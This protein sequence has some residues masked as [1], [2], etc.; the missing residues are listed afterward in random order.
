IAVGLTLDEIINPVS[1]TSAMYE[2]SLD[3][4]VTKM[5]RFPFDKFTAGN[6]K[7]GTQMKATGEIM[8]LGR[9]FSESL[10]KGIRSLD[11]G[12][13]TFQLSYLSSLTD[14]EIEKRL[15]RADDERIF[16]LAEGLRRCMSVEELFQLTKI[17]RYFLMEMEQLIAMET[18][19]TNNKLSLDLLK[20]AK[21]KGISDSHI[22]KLWDT[23]EKHIFE[24]RKAKICFSDEKENE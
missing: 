11:I 4:V 18:E 6:R 14:Q 12:T 3:Y 20:K 19:L 17:N 5:P 21:K 1:G 15:V 8:A 16:V 13:N 22:A 24:L 10:L 2:P 23:S 9:S 7:L